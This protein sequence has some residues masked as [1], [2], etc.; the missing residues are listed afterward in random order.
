MDSNGAIKNLGQRT[1]RQLHAPDQSPTSLEE[2]DGARWMASSESATAA[3]VRLRGLPVVDVQ[4]SCRPSAT[5][6]ASAPPLA[7]GSARC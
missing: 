7:T 5:S 4:V 6:L 1:G 2:T 3:G